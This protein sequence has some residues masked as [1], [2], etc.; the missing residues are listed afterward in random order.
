LFRERYF[1]EIAI[2]RIS[3]EQFNKNYDIAI[4]HHLQNFQ[5]LSCL[6]LDKIPES[7]LLY[8]K[9]HFWETYGG[10]W[11]Y[12]QV[13]GWI[14]LFIFGSQIRGELWKMTGKNFTRKTRNQ[15]QFMGKIFE[16][17]CITGENS[18]QILKKLDNEL[19][20][21]QKGLGKKKRILDLQCF[22]NLASYIDWRKL[23]IGSSK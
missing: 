22:K 4:K 10:P 12:N 7:N 15:I 18:E 11:N 2:Y 6:S 14:R 17:D 23:V 20:Q 1:F 9:Q 16:I 8:T 3:Y 21:I 19:D 13:I 5:E